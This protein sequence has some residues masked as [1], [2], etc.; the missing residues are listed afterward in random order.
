MTYNTNS[1]Y[2]KVVGTEEFVKKTKA[3]IEK[4]FPQLQPQSI[5]LS[6]KAPGVYFVFL[7]EKTPLSFSYKAGDASK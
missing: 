2:I 7:H 4:D 6:D 3:K 1:N 5:K